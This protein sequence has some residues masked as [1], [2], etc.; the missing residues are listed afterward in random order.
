MSDENSK[1]LEQRCDNL[2]KSLKEL[3]YTVSH[4]FNAPLRHIREFTKMLTTKYTNTE[5]ED[6]QRYL[7]IIHNAVENC[8][9]MI[10]GLLRV[11]R[12]NTSEEKP[13]KINLL[14]MMSKLKD[15]ITLIRKDTPVNIKYQNL[16]E[17]HGC[18][19]LISRATLIA[20][21]INC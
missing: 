12:A 4:D 11:S 3:T 21:T 18:W 16:P 17:I 2:E 5:S 6:A 7:R 19:N 20:L 15:S 8:E 10:E 9:K 1:Y 14:G 13:D